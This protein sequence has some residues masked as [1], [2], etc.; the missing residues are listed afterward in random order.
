MSMQA[1]WWAGDAGNAYVWRNWVDWRA[2]IPFWQHIMDLTGARS[3]Y[4]LGCNCGW[5]LSAIRRVS[6][7]VALYGHDVNNTALQIAT[8]AGLKVGRPHSA[9]LTF[10]CGVLIHVAP[11]DLEET[12]RDLIAASHRYVLAV[13]YV[14]EQEEEVEYRGERALLWRRPYG[15][16]YEALGLKF[17]R[18]G[19]AGLGFDNC[20]YWLMEK[21]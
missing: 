14:A 3:V 15:R 12:M 19:D 21:P 13:E 18:H 2:R 6:P 10:T 16:L 7:D 20:R 9:D 11:I 8:D 4:E 1:E 5:N 17:M